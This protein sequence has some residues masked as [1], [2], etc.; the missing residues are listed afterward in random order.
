MQAIVR[1]VSGIRGIVRAPPSKSYTHRAFIIASLADGTSIIRN[2]LL[3]GDT[4]STLKAIKA[5]NIETEINKD[6]VIYGRGGALE[7][8]SKP[9]DCENSGTTI[10][11]ICG[12]AS[13]NGEVIL[14]GDES[15]QKRPMQ[16]LLDALGQMGVK[17]YSTKGDGTPPVVIRGGGLAGGHVK[18]RGDISS[19]FISSLLIVAPYAKKNVII[20]ITTPLKSRPYIDITLDVMEKFGIKV[21][22]EDYN[23]FSIT[24]GRTYSA[25][26][27][28]IEGDYSSSSYF[29]AL[30]AMTNSEIRVENLHRNS[31]Q[32]DKAIADILKE[33]GAHVR[34]EKDNI[35]VK[36]GNLQG[37]EVDLRDTPDLLPTTVAL[38]CKAK[39]KTVI[40]NVEHARYKETDRVAACAAE[41][42]KF[43]VKIEERHDGLTIWGSETFRGATVKTYGDHRMAM[44]LVIAGLSAETPTVV[45]GVE[46][47]DISFP[48]FFK[49][50]E[51]LCPSKVKLE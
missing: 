35:I 15:V 22:K 16:P 38:A 25:T 27:Y 17:A 49:I 30:A 3:A 13:L 24:P 39:G 20:E 33:Y 43:G 51:R 8:P 14:S 37:I 47:V 5:F 44:A 19:Q 2:P 7:T 41:F 42:K 31:K 23:I 32:G 18:I 48:N 34:Y 10:R 4:Y 12:I 6:V 40:K 36:G 28:V 46:C 11:L 45:E 1:K 50:L 29:L 9:I 26:D 21:E